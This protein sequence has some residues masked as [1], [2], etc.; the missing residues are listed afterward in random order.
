M[1]TINI[2]T[3]ITVQQTRSRSVI[4]SDDR[5]ASEDSKYSL[6][7]QIKNLHT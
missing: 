2:I 3:I 6:R 7:E 4:V 5:E 1:V